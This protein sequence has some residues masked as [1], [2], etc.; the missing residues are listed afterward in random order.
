VRG[1]VRVVEQIDG[2]AEHFHAALVTEY[3]PDALSFTL[4]VR[5]Q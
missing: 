5:V 4:S 1:A 3:H 2:F